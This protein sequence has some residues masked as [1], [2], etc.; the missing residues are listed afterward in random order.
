MMLISLGKTA[1]T[2]GFWVV[3]NAALKLAKLL[4]PGQNAIK[5]RAPPTRQREKS[6]VHDFKEVK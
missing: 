2:F 1:G 4:P 6:I 3:L 5:R